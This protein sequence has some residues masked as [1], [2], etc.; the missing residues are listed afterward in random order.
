[1]PV[2]R[3]MKGITLLLLPMAFIGK[4]RGTVTHAVMNILLNAGIVYVVI[5]LS[6]LLEVQ[7]VFYMLVPAVFFTM[8]RSRNQR[9]K[10]R[11]GRSMEEALHNNIVQFQGDQPDS[12]Y[13]TFLLRREYV[14]EVTSLLGF[15]L[16]GILFLRS[17]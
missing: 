13:R 10:F 11:S 14:N 17:K 5:L 15:L 4:H 9:D 12:E 2:V 1:M 6:D 7:P 3:I 16:G 8:L